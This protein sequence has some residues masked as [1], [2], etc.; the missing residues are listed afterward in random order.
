MTESTNTETGGIRFGP[1]NL[2]PGIS[3]GNAWAL[4]CSGFTTIGLLTFVAVATPY[5]LTVYLGIPESEQGRVT[6]DLV[7][8][9]EITQI[10]IFGLVGVAADRFGRNWL[11]AMGMLAMGASYV[12]YPFADSIGELTIYRV[13]Y[14]IGLGTSTGMLATVVADYPKN[15][16]RGK[17]LALVGFLNGLGVILVIAVL[18]NLPEFL[19]DAGYTAISAGRYTHAVAVIGC[20]VTAVVAGFGLKKGPPAHEGERLTTMQ[21]ARSGLQEGR[22][23]RIALAYASAF[24]ARGDLVILGT[25]AILWGK[26]VGISQG[27]DPAEAIAKGTLVFVTAQASALLWIPLLGFFLDRVNRVTGIAFCM[28][29]ATVGYLGTMLV[30]DPT[31][32]AAIPVFV[33]LGIGQISAFFGS[34]T[35]IGQ[36]APES[37]RGS[38]VGVFNSA[39]A[40]GILIA[41]G[42]GGRLFDSVGPS[43]PFILV[44]VFNGMVFLFAIAVRIYSPGPMKVGEPDSS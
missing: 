4:M 38:V 31:S 14:A 37:K 3:R 21:L 8:W 27:M 6:G 33:M 17:M 5:V 44:G 23:P 18:G 25:F 24:V 20:L 7:F 9:A 39:G 10:L 29:L 36:E 35:L 34:A 22:N 42:I 19:V 11:Y 26:T 28:F 1:V 30:E 15:D 43:A 40:I 13:I 32:K 12:F 16:S 41:S 2:M